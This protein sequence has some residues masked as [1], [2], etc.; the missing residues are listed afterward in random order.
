M[1][2]SP[3]PPLPACTFL[4]GQSWWGLEDGGGWRMGFAGVQIELR[5]RERLTG[6]LGCPSTRLCLSAD[7]LDAEGIGMEASRRAREI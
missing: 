3:A 1:G 5:S 7:E 2:L 4:S 6:L